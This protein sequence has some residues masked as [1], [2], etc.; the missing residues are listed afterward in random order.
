MDLFQCLVLFGS[1]QVIDNC[2]VIIIEMELELSWDNCQFG[3]IIWKFMVVDYVGNISDGVYEQ[4]ID[5]MYS[6][7]Y[8]VCFLKDVVID[9]VVGVEIL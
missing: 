4:Q 7:I 3:F 8:S 5:I 9:C 1:F 2:V 6:N